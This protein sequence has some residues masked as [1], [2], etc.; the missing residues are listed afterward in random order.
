MVT[1]GVLSDN[2]KGIGS[3]DVSVPKYFYKVLLDYNQGNVKMIAFLVPHQ[4]SSKPLYEFVVSVDKIEALT[5]IDFF[6]QLADNLEEKLE[7]LDSYK[8][9]S[10]R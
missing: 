1:G 4:E 5:G 9:W 10:F 7:A 2:L 6:P 8:G 3:E